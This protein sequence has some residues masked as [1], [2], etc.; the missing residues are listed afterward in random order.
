VFSSHKIYHQHVS[1]AV[2]TIISV[3]YKNI[4]NPNNVSK[5][6][7]APLD[8]TRNVTKL[9]HNH[10]ISVYLLLKGN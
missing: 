9:L 3:T 1:L 8:V 2:E 6:V 7:S 4:W 10:W 5:Y